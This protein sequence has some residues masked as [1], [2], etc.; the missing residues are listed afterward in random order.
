MS[1]GDSLSGRKSEDLF[2]KTRMSFGEHLDEL[3]K[4][5]I[6]ALIGAGIGI[7]IG[8]WLANPVVRILTQ[9]LEKAIIR[10]DQLKA[11][12]R[13]LAD[14]GWVDPETQSLLDQ[15]KE[16]PR[17]VRIDVAQLISAIR[18]VSPDFLEKVDL[19]PWRFT[20]GHF[21]AEQL[22]AL[23]QALTE[24]PDPS[25]FPEPSPSQIRAIATRLSPE[26]TG[27][28][29]DLKQ[30]QRSDADAAAGLAAA[31]N[32][33]LDQ[34]DLSDDPAFASLLRPAPPG[35]LQRMFGETPPTPLQQ[36]KKKLDE[37]FQSDLNRRLNR[38]LVTAAFAGRIPPPQLDLVTLELW[39]PVDARPQSLS[40]IEGFMIWM[41]AGMITGLVLSGPW[42][43]YQLWSFVAAGLYPHEKKYVHLF[44]PVSI[45]LFALG[46]AVVFL[47][48]F[49]TVLGFFLGV[50]YSLGIDMQPRINDW[51]SFVLFLPLGFG[52]AFQLPLVMF[53]LNRINIFSVS[54][55]LSKWRIA[56]M[57]IF[58]VSMI[59]TPADPL[60]MLLL[61]V[62]L[63]FLYFFGVLLCL[64]MP[65]K[66][67]AAAN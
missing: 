49:D 28:L 17:P 23:L 59:L 7:A 30:G 2:E 61:A 14:Q 9:P 1:S 40:P 36:M 50:N 63:T 57:V 41:K 44:L 58:V 46:V 54:D 6:R 27:R 33:L 67:D 19:Q 3:R 5:L 53:F 10:F 13:I 11:G 47:F 18:S 52:L 45:A 42:I 8:F 12:E 15:R 31:L 21:P 16:T 51:L 4:T 25:L 65:V 34:R 22:P 24:Q 64:W 43:F 26:A 56:V 48:V 32:E 62:P 38:A 55:F 60:S 66:A 35:W 39:Q 20:A 37:G 29:G